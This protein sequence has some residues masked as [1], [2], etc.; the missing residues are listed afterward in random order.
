[1]EL[2]RRPLRVWDRLMR[3]RWGFNI[4]GRAVP[5]TFFLWTFWFGLGDLRALLP[6]LPELSL[7]GLLVFVLEISWRVLG[8]AQ[9]VL[10]AI[11]KRVVGRSANLLEALVAICASYFGT[12]GIFFNALGIRPAPSANP[13]PVLATIALAASSVGLALVAVS[14][15]FLGRHIGVLPEVRGFVSSGTYRWLRHPIYTGYLIGAAGSIIVQPSPYAIGFFLGYWVL[16]AWRAALEERAFLRELGST[17]REYVARTF[18]VGPPHFLP[19]RAHLVAA[20]PV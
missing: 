4:F 18:G 19:S 15:L 7:G 16:V 11:R 3:S 2:L 20:G 9:V 10:F 14:F 8:M 1:M 6:S 13:D 12:V 17:Y 5:S